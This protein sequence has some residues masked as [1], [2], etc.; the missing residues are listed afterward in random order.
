MRLATSARAFFQMEKN[1]FFWA[2]RRSWSPTVCSGYGGWSAAAISPEG[3]SA[4]Q[5]VSLPTARTWRRLVPI[6]N[7]LLLPLDGAQSRPIPGFPTGRYA[8][9][10]AADGRSLYVYRSGELPA[11][12]NRLELA[13][14]QKQLWKQLMPPTMPNHRYR[15]ILVTPDAKTYVYEIRTHSL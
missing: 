9:C 5:F 14:G 1:V 4:T 15:P 3:I 11:Q 6:S 8:G 2:V 13:G 7:G 10:V 12:V